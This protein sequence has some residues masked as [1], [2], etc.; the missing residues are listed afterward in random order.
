MSADG[1]NVIWRA[2]TYA[3]LCKVS[4]FI[5][6][7][8]LNARFSLPNGLLEKENILYITDSK[9]QKIRML[10]MD[11]EE[12]FD[13]HV[14]E[15]NKLGQFVFGAKADEYYVNSH[16][17]ILKIEGTKEAW[18]VGCRAPEYQQL[19][20]AQFS[21]AG[22]GYLTGISKMNEEFLLVTDAYTVK[23][24]DLNQQ[25]VDVIC[26]GEQSRQDGNVNNC[27]LHSPT[28]LTV[29]DNVILIGEESVIRQ[30]PFSLSN[31]LDVN[32]AAE[33][34]ITSASKSESPE[35][36]EL[37]C[38]RP[39]FISKSWYEQLGAYPIGATV[40]YQCQ[41]SYTATN[42]SNN[43]LVCAPV[44]GDLVWA[45][46][47]IECSPS[48]ALFATIIL[49]IV[50]GISLITLTVVVIKTRATRCGSGT[51]KSSDSNSP[52]FRSSHNTQLPNIP[53]STVG[54]FY[55]TVGD[56]TV[57]TQYLQPRTKDG[58][59]DDEYICPTGSYD[60]D[61]INLT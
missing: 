56:R 27:M 48:R 60:Y 7:E 55:E 28:S 3:G 21:A 46:K 35:E 58:R 43:R 30:I 29:I 36:P 25:V 44:Q 11:M 6:G 4:G 26:T 50:T 19:E 59:K 24:V 37:E 52:S 61:D 8:K 10:D 18:L 54:E 15:I 23:V 51:P 57:S 32:V 45:G 13:V 40:V 1:G 5:N 53:T 17:G 22:F 31:T 16:T 42:I 14:S 12:V 47:Y 41:D 2:S 39:P 33:N 34:S 49:S 20:R 38:E 9:N